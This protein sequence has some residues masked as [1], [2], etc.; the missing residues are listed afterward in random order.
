MRVI[1]VDLAWG[2][3][4]RTGLC[5]VDDARVLDSTSVV[6]D[7]DVDGWIRRWAADEML[8]AIDAPI[9]VENLTGCRPA[10]WVL[11]C[12]YGREHAGPHP[13][14]RSMQSFRDGT[15]ALALAG[16]L[17]LGVDPAR[18]AE[19]PVRLAIEVYPHPALVCLFGLETTLKYKAKRHR[20]RAARRRAFEELLRCLGKLAG[21]DPALDV[22][23]SPRWR[24]LVAEVDRATSGA[25]LDRIEDELDAYL[26]AYVGLYHL[27]WHGSRSLTVGDLATGYIVTPVD[28]AHAERLRAR[29][30]QRGVPVG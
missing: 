17:G 28:A 25:G 19:R 22:A 6:T 20:D 18:I 4:G 5:A 8:V 29:A 13:A 16:R 9:V 26:C 1:G 11:G 14:N 23:T 7:A 21:F 24:V 15:R 12:A 27:R 2:P 10:D 30:A 3:R